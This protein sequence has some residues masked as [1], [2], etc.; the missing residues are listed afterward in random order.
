M[1]T[2]DIFRCLGDLTRARI[3]HLLVQRGPELCVC[4]VVSALVLPQSTVSRQLM[5]LRYLELV[6]DRREGIWMHYSVIPPDSE[7]HRL[8]IE[9]IRRGFADELLFAEDLMRLDELNAVGK[10][11]GRGGR[12]D[13]KPVKKAPQCQGARQKKCS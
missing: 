8:M 5:T 9:M 2:L 11:A 6:K 3:L 13:G 12:C 1:R 4:D 10:V 7:T